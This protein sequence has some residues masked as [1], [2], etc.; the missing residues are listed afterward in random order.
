MP[1]IRRATSWWRKAWWRQSIREAHSVAVNF[2]MKH[3]MA[4]AVIEMP[5]TLYHITSY[6][7]KT[8]KC[9]FYFLDGVE[10]QFEGNDQPYC[11]EDHPVGEGS[12]DYHYRLRY[13]VR[14]DKGYTQNGEIYGQGRRG[15]TQ[16]R[17]GNLR[18]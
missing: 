6:N 4:L 11:P 8:T 15:G 5:G 3:C 7:S 10:A 2:T 14:P 16:L 9:D 13:I 18:G 1:T 17:G 12:A